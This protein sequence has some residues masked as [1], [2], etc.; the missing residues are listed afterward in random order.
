MQTSYSGLGSQQQVVPFRA[1]GIRYTA[2]RND[3][4][5]AMAA[6]ELALEF[7]GRL[8]DFDVSSLTDI[9]DRLVVARDSPHPRMNRLSSTALRRGRRLNVPLTHR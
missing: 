4:D 5:N 2:R 8:G 9:R 1:N 6:I 7:V 3:L